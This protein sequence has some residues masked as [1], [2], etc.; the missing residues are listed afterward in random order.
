MVSI[1]QS[2][3]SMG[4]ESPGFIIWSVIPAGFRTHSQLVDECVDLG[5]EY[6]FIPK[7]LSPK[8]ALVRAI[9]D[10]NSW[11]KTYAGKSQIGIRNP[12]SHEVVLDCIT[13]VA[14]VY[15]YSL[16]HREILTRE[17]TPYSQVGSVHATVKN[18][19][20]QIKQIPN[21]FLTEEMILGIQT[22]LSDLIVERSK[23]N[24]E[25]IRQVLSNFLDEK[26]V[27]LNAKGN[28]GIYYVPRG[29]EKQLR[30]IA[31]LMVQIDSRNNVAIMDINPTVNSLSQLNYSL[32][33][34]IENDL[35]NLIK[36]AIADIPTAQERAMRSMRSAAF[37]LQCKVESNAKSIDPAFYFPLL[38]R[39]IEVKEAIQ[40]R[41]I[42]TLEH[43][44]GSSASPS[45]PT[46]VNNPVP[47]NFPVPVSVPIE[48]PDEEP[49]PMSNNGDRVAALRAQ[50]AAIRNK[51]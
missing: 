13:K 48:I 8:N 28:G 26:G 35:V 25:E 14:P 27:C 7:K 49:A 16:R 42:Q 10:L 31:Q 32:T 17:N 9:A 33:A 51:S 12:N 23:F 21:T 5:I 44:L 1:E 4:I 6:R 40:Y 38:N 18:A 41:D 46:V 50:F 47:D 2:L 34:G 30:A 3:E 24:V 45:V 22:K 43:L 20:F 11:L 36:K 19:S 39:I 37:D 29:E 15:T